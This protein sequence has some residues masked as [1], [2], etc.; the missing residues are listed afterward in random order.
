VDVF[1]CPACKV[2]PELVTE[3][4][5][6]LAIVRHQL[7]CPTLLAQSRA[8]WVDAPTALPSMPAP[9]PFSHLGANPR[10]HKT[11]QTFED[12]RQRAVR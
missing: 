1:T 6:Q 4:N 11:V 2:T 3:G 10:W 8:R 12:R 7:G 9:I 5:A